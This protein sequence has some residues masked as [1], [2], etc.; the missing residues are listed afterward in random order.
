MKET[1]F[2][3]LVTGRQYLATCQYASSRNLGARQSIYRYLDP[4]VDFRLWA[5]GQ[6]SW[7]GSERVLDVGCGNGLYLRL[8]KHDLDVPHVAGLDLSEG[9]IRDVVSGWERVSR[10]PL[11]VAEA[12]QLPLASGC[13]DVVLAM[14]MLYH[15]PDMDRAVRELVR[16][17]RPGGKA[18]ISTNGDR[19]LRE[20]TQL[21]VEAVTSVAGRPPEVDPSSGFRFRLDDQGQQ[22]LEKS[23]TRV[24]R[25]E[26]EGKLR[27]PEVEAVIYYLSSAR[28]HREPFLPSGATWEAVI[29]EIEQKL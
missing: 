22:L 5:L 17:L 9:M 6:L 19:H 2:A 21:Y 1:E 27:V 29:H 25:R 20:L 7:S 15:V 11:A 26:L 28:T 10:P 18:L 23:F 4:P 13:A 3:N 24:A 14:H 16:V 8:L 12:Q